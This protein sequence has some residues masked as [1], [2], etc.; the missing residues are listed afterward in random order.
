MSTAWWRE[1]REARKAGLDRADCPYGK[2]Y[3][4]VRL[5]EWRGGWDFMDKEM[6]ADEPPPESVE[7]VQPPEPAMEPSTPVER[8]LACLTGPRFGSHIKRERERSGDGLEVC[9]QRLTKVALAQAIEV[10][11]TPADFR[12]ILG[13]MLEEMA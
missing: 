3:Q 2:G 11:E 10:A 13:R 1:G 6:A 12:L 9:K 7:P 5:R 4:R 8:V